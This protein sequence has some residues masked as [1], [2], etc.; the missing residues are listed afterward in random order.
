ML[1]LVKSGRVG[2]WMKPAASSPP[3]TADCRD[4]DW[5]H[6]ADGLQQ[7]DVTREEDKINMSRGTMRF[8]SRYDVIITVMVGVVFVVVFPGES[9]TPCQYCIVPLTAQRG[10]DTR[11]SANFRQSNS[12]YE[13][14]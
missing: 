14:I 10:M 13:R 11:S 12:T 6:I 9:N 4:A 7:G 1:S 5:W 8:S 2:C 3:T